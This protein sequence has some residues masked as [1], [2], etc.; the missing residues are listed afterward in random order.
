MPDTVKC[1]VASVV[2][3]LPPTI[4]VAPLRPIPRLSRTCPLT[5]VLPPPASG[6]PDPPPQ[7]MSRAR[8]VAARSRSERTCT[9]FPQGRVAI[10]RVY[11]ARARILLRAPL[12]PRG[13]RLVTDSGVVP[14]RE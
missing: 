13:A 14:V 9:G 6:L 12:D 5:V 3:V 11:P 1:P 8:V 7:P 2:V 10:R 4:T